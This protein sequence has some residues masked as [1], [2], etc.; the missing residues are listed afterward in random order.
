MFFIY[1]I[2]LNDLNIKLCECCQ[3]M[4]GIT[5]LLDVVATNFIRSEEGDRRAEKPFRDDTPDDLI[6]GDGYFLRHSV[7]EDNRINVYIRKTT[8]IPGHLWN[9]VNIECQPIMDFAITEASLNPRSNYVGTTNGVFQ[10]RAH[11]DEL[12]KILE[13]RKIKI[14]EDIKN[15]ECTEGYKIIKIEQ[16]ESDIESDSDIDI[17][18]NPLISL[19]RRINPTSTKLPPVH[20]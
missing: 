17:Q 7:K 8:I 14:D 1:S 6:T 5:N 9:S 3:T 4:D 12:K 13:A 11:L 10:N 19:Q 20:I 18:E 15:Y 16:E 2:N